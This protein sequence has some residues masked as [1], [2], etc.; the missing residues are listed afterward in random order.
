MYGHDEFYLVLLKIVVLPDVCSNLNRWSETPSALLYSHPY[1][2]AVLSR[3]IEV[4]TIQQVDPIQMIDLPRVK[5]VAQDVS[6]FVGSQTHVW[7]L[8]AKDF[9]YQVNVTVNAI[10]PTWLFSNC[11]YSEKYFLILFSLMFLLQMFLFPG[12][13]VDQSQAV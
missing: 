3:G 4:K 5:F 6:L 11:V 13:K 8:T 7:K 2:L 9:V 12:G 1:V 10:D